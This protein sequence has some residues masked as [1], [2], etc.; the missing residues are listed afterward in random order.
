MSKTSGWNFDWQ[1]SLMK[2]ELLAYIVFKLF[3]QHTVFHD[4]GR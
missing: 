4:V 1:G 3:A 2:P